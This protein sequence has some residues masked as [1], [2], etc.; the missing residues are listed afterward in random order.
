MILVIGGRGRI[1][2][3]TVARLLAARHDVRV[4]S[5]APAG[6]GFPAG[7]EIT[8]TTDW[9]SALDGVT[10]VLLYADPSGVG[11]IV[12]AAQ[13]ADVTQITLVSTADAGNPATSGSDPIVGMHR[14]A[15]LTIRASGLPWTF[16]RPGSLAANTL[17]WAASIRAERV[18]RAPYPDA[19]SALVH[20]DDIAEVA[21]RTLT[22]RRPAHHGQAYWLTGPASLSQKEQAHHISSAIGVSIPFE[23]ITPAQYR[24]SLARWADDSLIDAIIDHLRLAD[25]CPDLVSPTFSALIGRPSTPFTQWATDHAAA[26]R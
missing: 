13:A 11:D 7:V 16:L 3:A 14:A 24:R 26:F 8:G 20:E 19:H 25:G 18:V 9:P 15:E 6:L 17:G 1:A 21:A 22:D 12:E 5:R 2:R 4:A 23:E 10:A